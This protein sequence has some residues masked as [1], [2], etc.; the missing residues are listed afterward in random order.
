MGVGSEA[1]GL[2]DILTPSLLAG[3][4]GGGGGCEMPAPG[5]LTGGIAIGEGV[6]GAG[7]VLA[8]DLIRSKTRARV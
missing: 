4:G 1:N 5:M 7:S 6:A 3:G 8:I 2:K